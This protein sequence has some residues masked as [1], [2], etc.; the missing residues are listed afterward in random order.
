MENQNTAIELNSKYEFKDNK[1]PE[2]VYIKRTIEP[3]QA[4]PGGEG[5]GCYDRCIK[6]LFCCNLC[7]SCFNNWCVCFRFCRDCA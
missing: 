1:G 5:E 4:R 7:A 3:L 2:E 6:F